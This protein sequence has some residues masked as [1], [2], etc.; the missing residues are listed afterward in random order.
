[1]GIVFEDT[2]SVLFGMEGLRVTDAEPGPDGMVTVRAVTDHP[3]AAD[4]P[5]RRS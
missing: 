4:L 1:M 2:A 3:D 5:A